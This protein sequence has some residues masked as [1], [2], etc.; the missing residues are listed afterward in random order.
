M[1]KRPGRRAPALRSL[2]RDIDQ[3]ARAEFYADQTQLSSNA[4]QRRDATPH[5]CTRRGAGADRQQR[6]EKLV[7]PIRDGN[8][9][10]VR[11]TAP[12]ASIDPAMI[13]LSAAAHCLY[14]FVFSHDLK[15]LPEEQHRLSIG[16]PRLFV[17]GASGFMAFYGIATTGVPTSTR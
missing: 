17:S 12:P 14:L 16:E 11:G 4:G 15:S 6:L 1:T 9:D 2:P 8:K 3:A 13:G 10:P 5:A 7:R